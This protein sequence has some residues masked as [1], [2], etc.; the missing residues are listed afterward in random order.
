[1]KFL[2]DVNVGSRIARAL[3]EAGHD[4]VRMALTNAT[5]EDS[6]ILEMAVHGGRILITY[7]R[8]FSELVFARGATP[9]PAIIYL[10]YRSRDVDTVIERLMPLLNF[11]FLEDHLTV[12]DSVRVRRAPFI[13]KSNDNG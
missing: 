5:A 1:M 10:R 13:A 12:I 4:V 8:D 6:E 7:D 9:P 11:P 2:L 3:V